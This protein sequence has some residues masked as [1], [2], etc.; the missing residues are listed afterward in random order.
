MT[1]KIPNPTSMNGR[2]GRCWAKTVSQRLRFL[3]SHWT[4]AQRT[5]VEYLLPTNMASPLPD[6]QSGIPILAMSTYA[7]PFMSV[8]A[9]EVRRTFILNQSMSKLNLYIKSNFTRE[10]KELFYGKVSEDCWQGHYIVCVSVWNDSCSV[11]T[12]LLSLHR[13][14]K[15]NKF[16]TC[17][18]S[19]WNDLK[20]QHFSRRIHPFFEFLHTFFHRW[21][22]FFFFWRSVS[23]QRTLSSIPWMQQVIILTDSP[24]MILQWWASFSKLTVTLVKEIYPTIKFKLQLWSQ[25]LSVDKL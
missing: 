5:L 10:G 15:Q 9:Q 22:K 13:I 16:W 7:L 24:S 3:A 21:S 8:K 17:L 1:T 11:L 2:N 6:R 12:I 25:Q 18:V 4:L 14:Y 20:M 19:A 23:L